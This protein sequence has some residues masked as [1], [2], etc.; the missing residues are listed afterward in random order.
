MSKINIII[1]DN[2]VFYSL[3]TRNTL[4]YL[5]KIKMN[6]NNEKIT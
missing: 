5:P 1:Y 4:R 3:K 2:M 6:I